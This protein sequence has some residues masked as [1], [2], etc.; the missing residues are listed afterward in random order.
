MPQGRPANNAV[1]KEALNAL[2]DLYYL[3]GDMAAHVLK[4]DESPEQLD[5]FYMRPGGLKQ[6]LHTYYELASLDPEEA[7]SNVHP[8]TL[9]RL[10]PAR[11]LSQISEEVWNQ[12]QSARGD[13]KLY[14]DT[15]EAYGTP[16]PPEV[17]EAVNTG[18][19]ILVKRIQRTRLESVEQP[20]SIKQ[21][22]TISSKGVGVPGDAERYYS[23]RGGRKKA[24]L[25]ML[26]KYPQALSAKAWGRLVNTSNTV[27]SDVVQQVSAD[28]SDI[29]KRFKRNLQ[30]DESLI[31]NRNGYILNFDEL[32]IEDQT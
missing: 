10:L 30:L 17:T 26:D 5:I 3:Y 22:V 19:Q 32:D 18:K 29:N 14:N 7:G 24:V 28:V 13:L 12:I 8:L 15:Q 2:T 1:N 11:T 23:F 25:E 27:T 9:E 21:K 6:L 20:A 4:S 31:I 16:V